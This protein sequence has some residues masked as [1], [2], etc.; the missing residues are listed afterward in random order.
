MTLSCPTRLH[1]TFLGSPLLHILTAKF[2]ASYLAWSLSISILWHCHYIP[3]PK[4]LPSYRVFVCHLSLL[5]IWLS[6]MC[7]IHTG[8]LNRVELKGFVSYNSW[9]HCCIALLLSPKLCIWLLDAKLANVYQYPSVINHYSSWWY[10]T[11]A[12]TQRHS[13]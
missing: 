10:D 2:H 3:Q 8:H 7:I 9:T 12:N 5:G 11:Q 4:N 6:C 13:D 1:K